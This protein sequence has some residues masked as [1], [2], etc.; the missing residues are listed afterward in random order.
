[1]VQKLLMGFVALM[2]VACATSPGRPERRTLTVTGTAEVSVEPD[3]CYMTFTTETHGRSAARAYKDNM[4]LG[5]KQS[6]AIKALGVDPKDLQTARFTITPE[7]HYTEYSTK[8][9]F[10]GYRVTNALNVKVRDLAK[11]SDVLDAAMDAGA[12]E[13]SGVSFTVENPKK[14]TAQAREDAFKAAREKAE[15]IAHLTGIR[16][17]KPVSITENEPGDYQWRYSNVY[18][19]AQTRGGSAAQQLETGEVLQQGE[20]KI[21][22]SVQVVYEME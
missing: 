21:K 19:Q 2:L 15:K 10:D 16:L 17:S 3:I 18:P 13:V 6:T 8:R 4:E 5:T 20:I 14:Y 22:H 12:T 11:V 9:I 1:M 7:Y